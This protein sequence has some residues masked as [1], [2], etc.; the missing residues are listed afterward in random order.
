MR[1]RKADG[2]HG[3]QEGVKTGENKIGRGDSRQ[4]A[5]LLRQM[6]IVSLRLFGV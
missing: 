4:T 5:K 3:K 1:R 2:K 6:Q